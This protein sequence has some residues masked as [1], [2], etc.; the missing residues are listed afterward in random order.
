MG[1]VGLFFRV[2]CTDAGLR[3]GG[4]HA[5]NA[6]LALYLRNALEREVRVTRQYATFSILLHKE[7]NKTILVEYAIS[8]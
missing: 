1:Q 7:I 5:R 6:E 3:H 4:F 2:F 8:L